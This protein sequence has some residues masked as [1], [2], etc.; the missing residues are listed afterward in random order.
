MSDS[1]SDKNSNKQGQPDIQFS[2][3]DIGRWASRQEDPFA[4]QNRKHAAKK[5]KRNARRQKAAPIIVIITGAVLS[6]AAVVGLVFLVI[7]LANR[8]TVEIEEI[9]GGTTE[10]IYNYRDILQGLY[11]QNSSTTEAGK[12]EAVQNAVNG[13][14]ST[15]KGREYE[16][17]VKMAQALVYFENSLYSECVEVGE[18]IDYSRI[19]DMDKVVIYNVMYYSYS[20]IG[21]TDLATE[22]L[23]KLYDVSNDISG[24]MI[25]E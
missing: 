15:S 4:A 25:T 13:T 23:D 9:S 22:Y 1:Q 10:D 7:H 14:L 2:T 19:D 6:V 3:G 12:V 21:N 24:E 20:K 11:N 5:Q 16:A 17:Q 8:N 18:Q